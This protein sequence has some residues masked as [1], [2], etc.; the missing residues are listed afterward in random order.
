MSASGS[1]ETAGLP[2][3]GRPP[4]SKAEYVH[5]T[6]RHEIVN[7][8]HPPGSSVNQDEVAT[9]LGVSITPV[10]EALRRLESDGLVTYRAHH[11]A[12]VSALGVEAAEELRLLRA[13]VEGLSARLAAQRITEGQLAELTAVHDRMVAAARD[14]ADS[15]E[16]ARDSHLFH[17]MVADIGGPALLGGHVRSLRRNN[18]ILETVSRWKDPARVR[19]Y[20]DAHG[21]MLRAFAQGDAEEAERLMAEHILASPGEDAAR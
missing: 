19:L 18:P 14:S 13:S 16:L 12:T 10:R 8:V 15:Q 17:Q 6:L 4:T 5:E 2:R 7:G 1:G 3:T 9:R 11:G 21:E 20:L